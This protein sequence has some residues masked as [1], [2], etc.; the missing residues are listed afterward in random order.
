MVLL[1]WTGRPL[2]L[3]IRNLSKDISSWTTGPNSKWFHRIV[4]HNTLYQNCTNGSAPLNKRLC[5]LQ[6]RNIFNRHLLNHWSKS[7]FFYRIVPLDTLYQ[8]R[9]MVQ[10]SWTKGRPELQIRNIFKK[11]LLLNHWFQILNN[12]TELFLIIPSTKIS[13]MVLLCWTK[14]PPKLQIRKYFNHISWTTVSNSKLLNRIFPHDAFY[15]NC[16]NGS[17]PPN[18]GAARPLDKKC[19]LKTL[20]PEPLVQIQNYLTELFLIMPL[21]KLRIW[22]HSTEKGSPELQIWNIF[23]QH[24]LLNHCSKFKIISQNFPHDAIYQNCTNGSAPPNKWAAKAL[25]KNDL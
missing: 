17:A 8:N 3:Q 16:T 23:K 7:K 21:P 11:R 18:M 5:E 25:D 10:L 14:E 24:P 22:F 12:F 4:P 6:I 20:P 13:Q 9:E 19:L 2:E 15:K 1:H